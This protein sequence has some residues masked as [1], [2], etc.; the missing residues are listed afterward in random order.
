MESLDKVQRKKIIITESPPV[1][2]GALKAFAFS[3]CINYVNN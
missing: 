2:L 1:K 3:I